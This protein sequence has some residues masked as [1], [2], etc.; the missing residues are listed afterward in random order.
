MMKELKIFN[1]MHRYDFDFAV[2]TDIKVI[3]ELLIK[4]REP[5]IL[6]YCGMESINIYVQGDNNFICN[7]CIDWIYEQNKE[8]VNEEYIRECLLK[9]AIEDKEWTEQRNKDLT[10]IFYRKVTF[11]PEIQDIVCNKLNEY[12]QNLSTIY[13]EMIAEKQ[14]KEKEINKQKKEW[15]V[16]KTF[17]NIH[18]TGGENGRDGYIDA[19]Y[20]S[21]NGDIIRMV[22]R[23]VFDVGCYSYPKRLEGTDDIFNKESWTEPEKQL[24]IWLSKFGEFSGIRM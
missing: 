14:Q 5:Q 1:R 8:K 7:D 20:T 2:K 18:P 9:C 10:G 19:E 4:I 12:L 21:Q 6:S 17:K 13:S 16:T 3:E 11:L 24:V 22:S 23:D 15:T